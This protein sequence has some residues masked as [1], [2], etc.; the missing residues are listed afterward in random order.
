[1]AGRSGWSHSASAT[2]VASA[3]MPLR[4]PLIATTSSPSIRM[5]A[6]AVAPTPLR[7]QAQRAGND[8]HRDQRQ[9]V[10]MAD[11]APPGAACRRSAPAARG[12]TRL[13]SAQASTG[14]AA[15]ATPM[16]N[17][18]A[19]SR[20]GQ[21]EGRSRAP[22]PPTRS[23]RGWW[24]A[25]R[26]PAPAPTRSTA[27]TMRRAPPIAATASTAGPPHASGD[28]CARRAASASAEAPTSTPRQRRRP[29]RRTGRRPRSMA[30][31]VILSTAQPASA[32]TDNH[33]TTW[34][35]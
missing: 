14:T 33:R 10:G 11:R 3:R 16:A 21:R 6:P 26:D 22:A 17:R 28:G 2:L 32:S 18:R 9:R 30:P 31:C 24:R 34:V 7:G 15:T 5:I 25:T 35:S 13:P 23:P 1:M 19:G 20:G 29:R 8:E 12:S 4:D 27:P